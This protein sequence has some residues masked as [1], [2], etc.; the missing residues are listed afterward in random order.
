[1]MT[2]ADVTAERIL[3]VVSAKEEALRFVSSKVQQDLEETL[4]SIKKTNIMYK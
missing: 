4:S 1:M 3:S 2:D